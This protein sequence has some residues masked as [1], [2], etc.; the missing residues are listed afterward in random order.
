M[1]NKDL[2]KV[3]AF[4]D[5][6]NRELTL[7]NCLIVEESGCFCSVVQQFSHSTIQQLKNDWHQRSVET[8]EVVF[9]L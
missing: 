2:Q 9:K 6:Q 4:I 8:L 5:S 1:K 7:L 3:Y